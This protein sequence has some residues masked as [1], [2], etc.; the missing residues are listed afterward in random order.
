MF[1]TDNE[2]L[3]IVFSRVGIVLTRKRIERRVKRSIIE[4]GKVIAKKREWCGPDLIRS[5]QIRPD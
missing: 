3:S 1:F 4:E 2:V 5:D